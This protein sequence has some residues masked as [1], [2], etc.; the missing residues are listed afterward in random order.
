MLELSR[1]DDGQIVAARGARNQVDPWQPYASLV[2]NEYYENGRVEQ[3]ATVFL[4]NRECPFRCLFCDLWKNTTVET[5]PTRAIATQVRQ[6][7]DN[8]PAG[9]VPRHIKLYNSGNFFD[10]RAIPT[11]EHP[12]IASMVNEANF[13][14]LIVENHP[15]LCGPICTDFANRLQGDLEVALGLETAQPEVLAVLN[16]QMTLEDFRWAAEFL[17]GQGIFLRSFVLLKPP[18][19][20]EDESIEWAIRSLEFAFDNG[21]RV[22]AVVPTR[23]GNGMLD[24]LTSRGQFTPPQLKSLETVLEE[25]LRLARGRVMADLW[26]LEQFSQCDTCLPSRRNRLQQMNLQQ[27][28]LPPINCPACGC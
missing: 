15:K 23:P 19:M 24:L 13:Q 26:D 1:F 3:V 5:V 7:L 10:K 25:G 12:A 18:F 6:A 22:A 16:K 20:E 28:I 14:T 8:L 9:P 21:V 2:E 27:E 17:R 4:T 11:A